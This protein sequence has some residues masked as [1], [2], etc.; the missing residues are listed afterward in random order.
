MV[1]GRRVLVVDDEPIV[2]QSCQRVLGELGYEV[3]TA[4][5][6]QEGMKQAL[7]EAFDLVMADLK[8]PDLDGME[9][10]RVLRRERPQI[11]IVIITGYGTVPSAVEALK[12][13]VTDYIEKPFEPDQLTEAAK[14]AFAAPPRPE[15]RIEAELVR[16]VLKRA[17]QKYMVT[18]TVDKCLACKSC[19]LACAVE[20]SKSKDLYEAI[21][22]TPR[23]RPRLKVAQGEGFTAPLM[24]RHCDDAPCVAACPTKALSRPDENAPV[25]V[26]PKLCIGCDSCILACPF[27]VI[28]P[29]SDGRSLVKCDQCFERVARGEK[30]ACVSA[31]PT[32]ALDF[33]TVEEVLDEKKQADLQRIGRSMRG[34]QG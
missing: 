24:C 6:G 27:G 13:G 1:A 14:R 12:L 19:E 30:P 33:K 26:D 31:C 7:A 25:V 5:S 3:E 20:H 8:L 28:R 32:H 29:G 2:T 11:A 10:I 9:L 16:E 17:P 22:E 23:P 18:V 15:A 4:E 21:T 34:G